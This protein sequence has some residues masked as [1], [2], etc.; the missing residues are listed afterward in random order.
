VLLRTECAVQL[1]EG[2]ER[3]TFCYSPLVDMY[4]YLTINQREVLVNTFFI[5]LRVI[6]RE[7][8][9]LSNTTTTTSTTTATT[10]KILKG[11]RPWLAVIFCGISLKVLIFEFVFAWSGN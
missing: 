11:N 1:L 9:K 10:T 5:K 2:E 6:E 4:D 8:L 7:Y 3:E